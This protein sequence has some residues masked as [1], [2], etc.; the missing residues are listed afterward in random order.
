MGYGGGA[1]LSIGV[2]ALGLLL[3]G[4]AKDEPRALPTTTT[5]DQHQADTDRQ[6]QQANVQIQDLQSQLQQLQLQVNGLA[7]DK[8]SAEALANDL[9]F[10][11]DKALRQL[12]GWRKY[13]LE[14]ESEGRDPN[15]LPPSCLVDPVNC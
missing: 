14:L 2:C 7:N 10:R 1:R 4:C 13:A 8:Q 5:F 11:L 3:A 6:L 9:S 15:V 12:D